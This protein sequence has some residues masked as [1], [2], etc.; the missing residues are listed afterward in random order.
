MQGVIQNTGKT[1]GKINTENSFILTRHIGLYFCGLRARFINSMQ[2]HAPAQMLFWS[3]TV[4][5][6]IGKASNWF[7]L[8]WVGLACLFKKKYGP[9]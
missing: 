1:P 4:R 8:I 5:I 7:L 9:L 6:S 2:Q 3:S